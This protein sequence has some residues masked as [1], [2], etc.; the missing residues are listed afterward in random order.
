MAALGLYALIAYLIPPSD[1]TLIPVLGENGKWGY[2]NASGREM[3]EFEWDSAALF[4]SENP[5]S[6]MIVQK[7]ALRVHSASIWILLNRYFFELPLA[8]S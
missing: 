3:I 7:K 6:I 5:M 2:I 4:D 1:D 8:A